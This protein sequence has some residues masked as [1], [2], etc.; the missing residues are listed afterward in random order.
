MGV[1][2]IAKYGLP[3]KVVFCKHCVMSNQR[4]SSSIEF[5]H[6][7]DHKHRTLNIDEGRKC[8]ACRYAEEKEKID[9]EAREK[10]LLKLLER[11]RRSDGYYDCIVPGSGGKD[12]CYAAHVLKYK[13]GMNV[14]QMP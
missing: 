5:T 12:S 9:W 4:P 2:L 1:E 14:L 10:E 11:F 13:Y 8:E 3:E 7:A 6:K